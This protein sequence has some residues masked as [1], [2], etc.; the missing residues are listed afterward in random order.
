M[1]SFAESFLPAA[2]SMAAKWSNESTLYSS[3]FILYWKDDFAWV[4]LFISS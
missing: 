2:K 3:K 4:G 1:K